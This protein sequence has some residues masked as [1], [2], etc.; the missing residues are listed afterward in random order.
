VTTPTPRRRIWLGP[1]SVLVVLLVTGAAVWMM[2][3]GTTAP[4]TGSPEKPQLVE[5]PSPLAQPAWEY[6]TVPCKEDEIC[7][8]LGLPSRQVGYVASRQAIYKTE[9][10]GKTWQRTPLDEPRPLEE[11]GRRVHVLHFRDRSTG[12][13]GTDRLQQTTDGGERWTEVRLPVQMR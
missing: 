11:E 10:G 4:S 6:F 9:D 7:Q 13:L 3:R 8:R 1:A 5:R 2:T 12:W